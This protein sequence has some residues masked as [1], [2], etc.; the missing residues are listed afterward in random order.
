[1]LA[2]VAVIDY[3]IYMKGKQKFMSKTAKP[4]AYNDNDRAIVK[5]LKGTDGM[6]IAEINKATGHTFVSGNIVSAMK[7][8]Y[9]VVF[10]FYFAH[11]FKTK[12]FSIFH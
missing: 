6:T 9:E 2:I 3:N 11:I 4:I 7:N 1:M 12:A 5:A 10:A 8:C